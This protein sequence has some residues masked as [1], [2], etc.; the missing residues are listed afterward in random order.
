MAMTLDQIVKE[1]LLLPHDQATEL[2]DRLTLALEQ[3]EGSELDQGWRREVRK[4][5]AEI[6]SGLVQPVDG[7]TVSARIRQIVGR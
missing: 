2:L 5:L 7:E 6:E 4:R 3:P 1:A